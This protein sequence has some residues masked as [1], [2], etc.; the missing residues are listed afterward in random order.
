MKPIFENWNKFL[1]EGENYHPSEYINFKRGDCSLLAVALSDLLQLPIYGVFDN[2]GMMH[3]VFVYKSQTDQAIDCRGWM[4]AKDIIQ[5]IKGD[6]LNY[7]KTS[8]KEV[9]KIFGGYSEEEYEY[10]EEVAHEIV[11]E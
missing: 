4:P 7:R 3:H 5:N 1:E 2:R 6:N 8:A 11:F 9:E 10:A